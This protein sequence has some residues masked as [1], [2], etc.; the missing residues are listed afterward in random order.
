MKPKIVKAEP[1]VIQPKT[2]RQKAGAWGEGVAETYLASQGLQP[3]ARNVRTPFGEI[4][5]ILLDR[6]AV[7]FVEV[8]TRSNLD[9]GQPEEAVSA[10]KREH[11]IHAAEA[12]IQSHIEYQLCTWRIDVVAVVGTMG[13]TDPEIT[14]F[15]NAVA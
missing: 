13:S 14:W 15:E 7:I 3:L 9:F 10:K 12:Y 1:K 5:L 11:L 8:K 4:D 2:Y 6:D